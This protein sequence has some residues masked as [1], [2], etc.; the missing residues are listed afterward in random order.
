VAYSI[1]LDLPGGGVTWAHPS[2]FAWCAFAVCRFDPAFHKLSMGTAVPSLAEGAVGEAANQCDWKQPQPETQ[3]TQHH[4][5][6]KEGTLMKSILNN[7]CV[8]SSL[9]ATEPLN[10][11]EVQLRAYE[12][13]EQRGR[14][15]GHDVEDWLQAEAEIVMQEAA[16]SPIE[17]IAA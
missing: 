17:S 9:T 3:F 1:R 12:L 15:H 6:S 14:E 10:S 4:N 8:N 5:V 7:T 11:Q 2:D 13:Y 16:P